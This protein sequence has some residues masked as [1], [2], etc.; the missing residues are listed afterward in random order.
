MASIGFAGLARLAGRA[1]GLAGIDHR[2]GVAQL[3]DNLLRG[4]SLSSWHR[5]S[6]SPLQGT[7]GTRISSGTSAG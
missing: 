2:L 5:M 4:E 1:Q 7:A 3:A 6:S